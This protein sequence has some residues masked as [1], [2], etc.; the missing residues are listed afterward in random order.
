MNQTNSEQVQTDIPV[1]TKPSVGQRTFVTLYRK[2]NYV[3]P[4]PQQHVQATYRKQR[5]EWIFGFLD[6]VQF[7]ATSGTI[8]QQLGLYIGL[9]VDYR[10]LQVEHKSNRITVESTVE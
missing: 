3:K 10:M 7:S 5:V 1:L 2:H 8:E 6:T 4:H 9:A